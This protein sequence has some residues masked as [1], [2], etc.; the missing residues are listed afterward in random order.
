M[1]TTTDRLVVTGATVLAVMAIAAS[2]LLGGAEDVATQRALD[3]DANVSAPAETPTTVA[4]PAPEPES[5][6]P[7]PQQPA[8]PGVAP[9]PIDA[10]PADLEP[11]DHDVQLPL[12][13]VP[14]PD[15][16]GPAISN[17]EMAGCTIH[18]DVSDP[19]G[20]AV[21]T[22]SWSG[23]AEPNFPDEWIVEP[24]SSRMHL[25]DG[26]VYQG[27]RPYPYFGQVYTVT[28]VDRTLIGNR[29]AASMTWNF[30]GYPC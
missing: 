25:V 9:D 4:L 11:P 7:A 10:A 2:T 20:V 6:E 1:G 29:S 15:R 18:A 17:I 21:V 12:N 14:L 22:L 8:R 19:A 23:V 5:T 16:T 24:G 27:S 28:A 26:V 3:S 13:P 30:H